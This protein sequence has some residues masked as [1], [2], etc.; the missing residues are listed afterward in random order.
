[1]LSLPMLSLGRKAE[2]RPRLRVYPVGKVGSVGIAHRVTRAREG[3]SCI[4]TPISSSPL[5]HVR[6][7]PLLLPVVIEVLL[8]S[9]W[10]CVGFSFAR[11][12]ISVRNAVAVEIVFQRS[13]RDLSGLTGTQEW[14]IRGRFSRRT[15]GKWWW[16][17]RQSAYYMM[18]PYAYSIPPLIAGPAS[19]T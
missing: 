14:E 1:M 5:P 9:V 18:S 10:S 19:T 4:R 16:C 2:R 8:I 12:R 6:S 17:E 11:E 3:R 7:L 13:E 15:Q